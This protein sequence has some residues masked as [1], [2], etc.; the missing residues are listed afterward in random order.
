MPEVLVGRGRTSRPREAEE[1]NMKKQSIIGSGEGA[2]P[3]ETTCFPSRPA[4][5][6]R[7]AKC[8][9]RV[10]SPHPHDGEE[11]HCG[12][13]GD[14]HPRGPN[15]KPAPEPSGRMSEEEFEREAA[16]LAKPY[17]REAMQNLS[18][19]AECRRARASE[20]EGCGVDCRCVTLEAERD[21]LRR[22]LTRT[23]DIRRR[24]EGCNDVLTLLRLIYEAEDI[25]AA[26]LRGKT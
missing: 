4:P 13:Y 8:N 10:S 24:A 15:C 23:A 7:C 1:E 6:P 20:A 26:A 18:I 3:V 14:W 5:E 22:A 2:D 17:G 19:L 12:A 16:L 11:C 21:A 25:A 9:A